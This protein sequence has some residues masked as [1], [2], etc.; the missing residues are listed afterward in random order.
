ME[1]SRKTWKLHE[2]ANKLCIHKINSPF[3]TNIY[4]LSLSLSI[5]LF[6][7]PTHS[8]EYP[9]LWLFCTLAY[10]KSIIL[11]L[12]VS[13]KLFAHDC[14]KNCTSRTNQC[15][16]IWHHLQQFSSIPRIQRMQC[17]TISVFMA[18]CCSVLWVSWFLFAAIFMG[19]SGAR[20]FVFHVALIIRPC[21]YHFTLVPWAH[22]R[23]LQGKR[24]KRIIWTQQL[25][26]ISTME[27]T[28][29]KT[30]TIF[31]H[32]VCCACIFLH[33]SLSVFARSLVRSLV[34]SA[35]RP[36]TRN[37]RERFSASGIGK[38]NRLSFPADRWA[39]TIL[40]N[41]ILTFNNF[42][43]VYFRA[44]R[45]ASERTNRG[46]GKMENG[47]RIEQE[48]E[49]N[50]TT[51]NWFVQLMSLKSI[52]W[53]RGWSSKLSQPLKEAQKPE[54]K[55]NQVIKIAVVIGVEWM[56]F[57]AA[58][59]LLAPFGCA[60]NATI[61]VHRIIFAVCACNQFN[62]TNFVSI[63][64][65]VLLFLYAAARWLR[66]TG[67]IV[68]LG[69]KFVNKFAAVALTCVICSIIAV[70]VGIFDNIYGNDK[71]QWVYV[72]MSFK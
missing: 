65:F 14:G 9:R 31:R 46:K 51:A 64:V 48:N 21:S 59:E 13:L 70:Y 66:H 67:M 58:L 56:C 34:A 52:V 7:V 15:R 25:K 55:S 69:V 20:L 11:L 12:Y 6:F 39:L 44:Q 47:M 10:G 5:S 57:F 36:K 32:F 63:V 72:L 37:W 30:H 8:F 2:N 24:S 41:S 38:F 4:R 3:Y 27:R 26:H 68:Y 1:A 28:K 53:H 29:T 43:D 61:Y 40:A 16:R 50:G 42:G 35:F 18:Q 22:S 71:L 19:D 23:L 49:M 60:T 54:P 45:N 17:T 33:F 62:V